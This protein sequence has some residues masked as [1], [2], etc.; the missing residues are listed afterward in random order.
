MPALDAGALD[1]CLLYVRKENAHGEADPSRGCKLAEALLT[2]ER[3]ADAAECASRAFPR[4]G[5]ETPMLRSTTSSDPAR[6][7][8]HRCAIDTN[9]VDPCLRWGAATSAFRR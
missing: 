7:S 2:A 1:A 8:I 9:P 3:H 5:N 6:R 4:L